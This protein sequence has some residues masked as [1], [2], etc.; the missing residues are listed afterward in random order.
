VLGYNIPGRMSAGDKDIQTVK[1][2]LQLLLHC[3]DKARRFRL[4][5]EAKTKT[6]RNRQTAQES[7]LKTT[8]AQRAEAAA[9]RREEKIRERK[10]RVMEEE[11]PEKQRRLEVRL[12]VMH[13]HSLCLLAEN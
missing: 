13:A 2:L 7:F 6:E 5:R 3:V 4:S 1:P 11:D 12:C 10:Q 8:H 9:A